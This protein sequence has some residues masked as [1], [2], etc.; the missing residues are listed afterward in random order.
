MYADDGTL[1]SDSENPK[2]PDLTV[3]E[4]GVAQNYEK[5]S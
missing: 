1:A 3:K 2:T 4:A 5:S